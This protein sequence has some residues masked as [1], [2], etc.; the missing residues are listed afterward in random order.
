MS[1][2]DPLGRKEVRDLIFDLR[3]QG[4]TVFFCTHILADATRLCDRV[5]IIVRGKLRDVGPLGQLL[6]PRVDSVDVVWEHDDDAS[7]EGLR[8]HPGEHRSTSEGQVL[9]VPGRDEADAFVAAV[10]A[11]GGHIRQVS[12]HRQ[13]LEDL[14]VSEAAK[15]D[16]G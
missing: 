4:K 14:F 1:G 11:A 16:E 9:T 7:R 15:E 12:P 8:E 5:A 2:L 13:G 10:V 6:D 3:D